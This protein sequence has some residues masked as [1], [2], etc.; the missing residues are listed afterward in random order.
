MCDKAECGPGEYTQLFE[1]KEKYSSLGTPEYISC[2]EIY[3]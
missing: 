1:Q 2:F 3:N